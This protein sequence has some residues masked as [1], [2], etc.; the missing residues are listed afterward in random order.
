[1]SG[2]QRR[3]LNG[4]NLLMTITISIVII[5]AIFGLVAVGYEMTAFAAK[6]DGSNG[7]K[8]VIASSNGFP[9]G[10]HFNLIIH[11]KSSFDDCGGAGGN[12]VFTPE[13]SEDYEDDQTLQYYINKKAQSTTLTVRD[14][15]TE[16]FDQDPAQVQL[17]T[18]FED[19][20]KITD[21]FWVFARVHGTPDNGKSGGDSNIVLTPDP[22]IEACNLNDEA[23]GTESDCVDSKGNQ[24]LVVEL[25]F[26]TKEGAVY[27]CAEDNDEIIDCDEKLYR[28]TTDGDTPAKGQGKGAK[29][30]V[31]IT[32][33]FLWSGIACE[34]LDKDGELTFDDFDTDGDGEIEEGE[35]LTNSGDFITQDHIDDALLVSDTD[36]PGV[37]DSDA[38]FNALLTVIA[39]AEDYDGCVSET[40]LWVFNLFDADLVI[41]NQTLTNDGVKNLQIR[42]YPQQ[43][44]TFTPTYDIG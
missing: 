3:A 22:K 30:A 19:G 33:L 26:V 36:D 21:G 29:K 35:G 27:K 13:Y 10:L 43:T 28:Y 8:D 18:K 2:K 38:D 32:P 5:G 7:S 17:P 42:F 1:V 44:T 9:S 34:D 11:G 40:D 4:N 6:P 16:G 20:T 39:E 25:G 41:Q 15:C 24:A 14:R 12:S 31:D 37:I 23:D